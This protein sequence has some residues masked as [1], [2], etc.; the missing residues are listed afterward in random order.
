M[1]LQLV[2]H[3]TAWQAYATVVKVVPISFS[4]LIF[5]HYQNNDNTNNGHI[6][7]FLPGSFMQKQN[8]D[9]SMIQNE[10]L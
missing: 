9:S 8:H 1:Q 4:R 7:K 6:N 5:V 3:L 2:G 10:L